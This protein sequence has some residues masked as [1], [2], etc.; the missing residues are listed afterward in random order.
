MESNLKIVLCILTVLIT[1]GMWYAY[2]WAIDKTVNMGMGGGGS[3]FLIVFILFILVMLAFPA[4]LFLA[5]AK[6]KGML[7]LSVVWGIT[8]VLYALFPLQAGHEIHQKSR[9]SKLYI[10]LCKQ[11][12]NPT[13]SWEEC[14]AAAVELK[15][16]NDKTLQWLFGDM[17][18]GERFDLAKGMLEEGCI[19]LKAFNMATFFFNIYNNQSKEN[20]TPKEQESRIRIAGFLLDHGCDLHIGYDFGSGDNVLNLAIREHDNELAKYLVSRE[21]LQDIK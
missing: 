13:S 5:V 12:D 15:Q 17:L 7:V 18:R 21:L 3:D 11:V 6:C 10:E 8:I 4:I 1:L 19:D 2:A 20:R 16:G 9:M 14:R